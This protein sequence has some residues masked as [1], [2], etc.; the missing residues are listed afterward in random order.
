MQATSYLQCRWGLH[1]QLP[2]VPTRPTMHP[3]TR[4][5]SRRCTQL[6]CL[7]AGPRSGQ[8]AVVAL[9]WA[10]RAQ[11]TGGAEGGEGGSE[12]RNSMRCGIMGAWAP[13][14]RMGS[15]SVISRA[16]GVLRPLAGK[17][18]GTLLTAPG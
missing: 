5:P 10:W 16:V 13:S 9:A 14:R 8:T 11:P 2:P 3:P 6:G 7:D 1:V 15:A 12:W 17:Q 18:R 4:S